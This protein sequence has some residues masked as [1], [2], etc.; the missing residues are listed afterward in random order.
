MKTSILIKIH[1]SYTNNRKR[2]KSRVNSLFRKLYGYD[3]YS[4]YSQY[5]RH[6]KGLLEEIPSV[7]YERGVIMIREEDVKKVEELVREYGAEYR[8]WKVIPG[9]QEMKQLKL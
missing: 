3:T 1:A 5:N 9:E 2:R 8:S 6:K 4:N 7:V